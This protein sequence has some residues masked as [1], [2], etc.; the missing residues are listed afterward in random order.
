M[1]DADVI[2]RMLRAIDR[3]DWATVRDS[4]TDPVRVD[5]TSLWGGE[6]GNQAI[7]DLIGQWTEFVEGFGAT[8]HQ[9][10][11]LLVSGDRVETHV[12]AR[13]WQPGAEHAWVVYGH[14]VARL[15]GGRIAELTLQ[16][17]HAS[18]DKDLPRIG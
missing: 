9:T 12:T 5:Y 18:G 17:F 15:E 8:H 2:T 14:Y 3:R 4:F 6:A 7:D 1:T 16:T 10:G 11:P 13:H